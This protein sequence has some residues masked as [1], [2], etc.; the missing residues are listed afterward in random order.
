MSDDS[1]EVVTPNWQQ[2]LELDEQLVARKDEYNAEHYERITRR[3][4]R[5]S[6][7]RPSSRADMG[8][9]LRCAR[10]PPFSP[11]TVARSAC[12]RCKGAV[13]QRFGA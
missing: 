8:R 7:D 1:V 9:R 2:W 4:R 5:R 3:S 13:A 11:C 12:A 6:R 10:L